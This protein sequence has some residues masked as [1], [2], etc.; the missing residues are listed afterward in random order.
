MVGVS[1]KW[2]LFGISLIGQG[3]RG[4]GTESPKRDE[5]LTALLRNL[6]ASVLL[7]LQN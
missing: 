5:K 1:K 2:T 3:R 7:I 4:E 6:I